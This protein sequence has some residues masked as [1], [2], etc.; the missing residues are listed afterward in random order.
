MDLE[1][2][3]AVVFDL[4]L[5]YDHSPFNDWFELKD[6]FRDRDGGTGLPSSSGHR[7]AA[8]SQGDKYH[9]QNRR[10]CSSGIFHRLHFQIFRLSR[11]LCGV[12]N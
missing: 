12:K 1:C 8:S 2:V 7:R 9:R 4:K 5:V 3:V 6:G 10:Q 11:F